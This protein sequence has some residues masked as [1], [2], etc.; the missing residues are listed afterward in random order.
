[1]EILVA[2]EHW[3]TRS[4]NPA[5]LL[6]EF[7]VSEAP[8]NVDSE[9][10]SYWTRAFRPF[11]AWVAISIIALLFDYHRMASPR[12]T[13][14]FEVLV[15]GK[16]QELEN[17]AF[18]GEQAVSSGSVVPIG[19]RTLHF[20]VP[21]CEPFS[22]AI[23]VWYGEN[24]VGSI[25]LQRSYGSLDLHVEPLP[26]TVRAEGPHHIVTLT[27]VGKTNISV[28]V[29]S[30]KIKT[31]FESF[32]D[33]RECT[34]VRNAT[35]RAEIRIDVGS[36][37][38]LSEPS[39]AAFSIISSGKH[40][41]TSFGQTPRVL[42]SLPA[43]A[44]EL[45][46]WRDDYEL[47]NSVTVTKDTTNKVQLRFL[48]GA[49]RIESQPAD[50]EVFSLDRK[51]AETPVTLE[52]L[53]LGTH[54][55]QL[56]KAG[57]VPIDLD[58][59]ISGTNAVTI[60]TNLVNRQYAE[61]LGAARRYAESGR[62]TD[63]LR[64]LETALGQYPNDNAASQLKQELQFRLHMHSAQ[65]YYRAQNYLK[66][67]DEVEAAL[68]VRPEAADALQLKSTIATTTGATPATVARQLAA[69]EHF[70]RAV[71][72]IQHADLFD[73]TVF[74]VKAEYA[75]ARE[76]LA[77]SIDKSPDKWSIASEVKIDETF[78]LLRLSPK[79]LLSSGRYAIVQ[80]CQLSSG[81]TEIRYKIWIYTFGPTGIS[82][83]V[84]V[85]EKHYHPED[86]S[87]ARGWRTQ[88]SNSF[89]DKMRSALGK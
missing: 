4:P 80:I 88:L 10:P 15:D 5:K 22:K 67:I 74:R 84:P 44:Y 40:R 48:Y 42:T 41:A 36:V 32:S 26:H 57:Y 73:T 56:V 66:A 83:N 11:F 12:T 28:P 70:N 54:R 14:T 61:A 25:A 3:Y 81:E 7:I 31:L 8:H 49:V 2:L 51:L 62:Y 82:E 53:K 13:I 85:H 65:A 46:M 45:R 47:T 6:T 87:R 37:A 17:A 24:N 71:G 30:Y 68:R 1:M 35:N 19:W 52:P 33:E 27:N 16:A 21:D 20:K 64:S 50:A 89:R 39:G 29:G 86:P 55:I 79:G 78:S 18:V 77:V 58:V 60:S 63:A 69:E 76:A 38:L 75:A 23:F 72:K 34:V 9:P 43:G 59:V